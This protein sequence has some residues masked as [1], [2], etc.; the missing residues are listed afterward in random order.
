MRSLK[1]IDEI[2]IT[3]KIENVSVEP[4]DIGMAALSHATSPA[5][6]DKSLFALFTKLWEVGATALQC[7]YRFH[8]FDKQMTSE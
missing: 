1:I 4:A 7:V 6:C 3:R 5:L 2:L 8:N